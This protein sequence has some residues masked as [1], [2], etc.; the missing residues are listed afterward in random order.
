MGY[1]DEAFE[2]LRSGLEITQTEK[3][4]ASRKHKE[5]RD[6]VGAEWELSDDFLTGSY[7]RETKTKRL[8]DVDIF[9]VLVADGAQEI[10]RKKDPY[11]PLLVVSLAGTACSG[12]L[13]SALPP[14]GGGL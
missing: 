1:V 14:S 5:I 4:F 13:L 10:L 12:G 8:K 6:H 11:S 2:N 7:S 9:V 3:G